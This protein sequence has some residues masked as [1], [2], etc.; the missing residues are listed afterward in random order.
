MRIPLPP[1]RLLSPPP[2]A[3]P[4]EGSA[5]PASAPSQPLCTPIDQPV[6]RNLG[7]IASPRR[8][9]P[10]RRR[11]FDES[12]QRDL[13]DMSQ[14]TLAL[15]S[16]IVRE[17]S[18]AGSPQKKRRARASLA[19]ASLISTLSGSEPLRNPFLDRRPDDSNDRGAP[20]AG[21]TSRTNASE[22]YQNM[23]AIFNDANPSNG[24]AIAA[25][26][27]AKKKADE[28]KR[29]KLRLVSSSQ[30]RKFSLDFEQ[31]A[32]AGRGA[33]SEVWQVVHRLDGCT[34]AV[35]KNI[36]PLHSDQ[37]RWDALQEVFALSALQNH[38]NIL[39]YNDAWFEEKG[40]YLFIQME[41]I[42]G[43]S[44]YSQYVGRRRAMSA[45]ELLCLAADISCALCSMHSKGVAHLD[46][47]PDNI[48]KSDRGLG[49]QSYI[50][51]DFGLACHKDGIDA[52]TTEGDARYLRPE[53]MAESARTAPDKRM[54]E[55]SQKDDKYF[56]LRAG[57]VF[58]LGASLYELGT[59][60]PLDKKRRQISDDK[61]SLMKMARELQARC[62]SEVVGKI[63]RCC[64]EPDPKLRATAQQLREICRSSI[65][66]TSDSI[67][68]R[69]KEIAELRNK[70]KQYESF[71]R[72]LIG[73]GEVGR[74]HYRKNRANV[75]CAIPPSKARDRF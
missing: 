28:M 22:S 3:L 50:I 44:L 23:D 53:A 71:A 49:R 29:L 68:E 70:L 69:L 31:K 34:Y 35:K 4:D 18:R 13:P 39:R 41:F 64:L 32:L 48:F 24:T 43:G 33:F 36:T 2:L 25:G 30:G 10:K 37:A 5:P 38:P 11:A 27:R 57:D 17:H 60:V 6:L 74:E 55:H 52:R 56:D 59:G 65:D 73:M 40:K 8:T 72:N 12:S 7:T 42:P 19:R 63:A 1:P 16:N 47:K 9:A 61:E 45:H 67:S 54:G 51:G 58:S 20:A 75:K 14:D 15:F 21:K 26:V 62:A 66:I 46:V